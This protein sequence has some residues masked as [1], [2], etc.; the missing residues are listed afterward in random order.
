MT[1]S[2]KKVVKK[3]KQY[4]VVRAIRKDDVSYEAGEVLDAY[5]LKGWPVKAW[6]QSGVLKE[7]DNGN[8]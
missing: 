1:Q 8:G 5:Q 3:N 2:T 6:L 7:A 4:L